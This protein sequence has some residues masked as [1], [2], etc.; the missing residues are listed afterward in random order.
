MPAWVGWGLGRHA[1][2]RVG[3]G[4][5]FARGLISR[6]TRRLGIWV[7][8]AVVVAAT[9]GVLTGSAPA[10]AATGSASTV[11]APAASS[12]G[13]SDSWSATEPSL[14]SNADPQPNY[15]QGV[16]F[17]ACP[18]I[19]RCDAFGIYHP[20]S[21]PTPTFVLS[22]L[23]T[24]WTQT[25]LNDT[26]IKDE[27]CM[28]PTS[29]VAVADGQHALWTGSG[30]S[31]SGQP[32]PPVPS[33][34]SQ[35]L[36]ADPTSVVCPSSTECVVAG[37]YDDTSGYR[38]GLL[39]TGSP[40]SW[41]S[42]KAPL[43]ANA[44]ADPEV[45][46]PSVA[47]S[48]ASACV[49]AGSYIDSAGHEDG[50]VLKGAGTSWTATEAPL[51]ASP[52]V[53]GN[54]YVYM[55]QV[56]CPAGSACMVV[57]NYSVATGSQGARSFLLT[58]SG[59]SWSVIKPPLPSNASANAAVFLTGGACASAS[60]C[61]MT[62]AYNLNAA[63][64]G[65]PLILSGHGSSW[66]PTKAP[67]PAGGNIAGNV[68]PTTCL[69][70]TECL[71]VGDYLDSNGQDHGLILTGAGTS[72]SPT[73]APLPGNAST[74]APGSVDLEAAA[75]ASASSCAIGG[76]YTDTAGALEPVLISGPLGDGSGGTPPSTSQLSVKTSVATEQLVP[77]PGQYAFV[78]LTIRVTNPDGTPA[79]NAAVK[80]SNAKPTATFHTNKSGI[81]TITE[82]VSLANNINDSV[83]VTVTA[84]NAAGLTGS[85]TQTLYSVS[86]TVTCSMSG[87]PES[88]VDPILSALPGALGLI[89]RAAVLLC[90]RRPGTPFQSRGVPD[91][92][93]EFQVPVCGKHPDNAKKQDAQIVHG[94]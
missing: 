10:M 49:A 20:S 75:C 89:R 52:A 54:P 73:T 91:N 77:D 40:G 13:A 35:P 16:N 50:L 51:P 43:P 68:G 4:A 92:R 29:C 88:D 78:K 85:A 21:G 90:A 76:S 14:P 59:T 31:W 53:S 15:W 7:V 32:Q 63:S 17:V 65:D 23:S 67:L 6:W 5:L 69:S 1:R 18:S 82:P 36:E 2:T 70:A 93:A 46:L 44:A 94:L 86:Q 30:T 61:I 34:A 74:T 64:Y 24:S 8:P 27:A 45:Q 28:S 55:A 81:V 87:I 83:S 66:T 12:A 62:G 42:A 48:S 47:C 26:R 72:W 79:S 80:L 39:V 56:L 57:G 37:T 9:S 58:D 84:Q 38:Q 11:Q 71:V 3:K 19:S 25:E 60:S 22:G 33:D 41:Q